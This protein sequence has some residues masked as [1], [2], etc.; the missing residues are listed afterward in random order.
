MRILDFTRFSV[1]RV[2]QKQLCPS[3]QTQPHAFLEWIDYQRLNRTLEQQSQR[4]H[5]TVAVT[6][7]PEFSNSAIEVLNVQPISGSQDVDNDLFARR[8]NHRRFSEV[9]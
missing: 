8:N 1:Q 7:A 6:Q 4:F 2:P 9:R 5:L 3:N